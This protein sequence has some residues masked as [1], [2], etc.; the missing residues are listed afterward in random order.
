MAN[1]YISCDRST[2]FLLPPSLTDWL[3]EDHLAWFMIDAVGR[4]DTSA[5]HAVHPS[6]GPGRAAYDPDMMLTLLLYAYCTGT[7]SSRQIERACGE[8][9]AYRVITANE[10]PDHGTI[11][12]FR[13]GCE[14]HIEALFIKVLAM[15]AEAGMARLGIVALDGTKIAA[16]ASMK[17][18]RSQ[19]QIQKEVDALRAR[20]E[21]EVAAM[22]A[23]AAD[24]DAAQ[25]RLFGVDRGD[26][27]PKHLANPRSRLAH[28]EAALRRLEQR[29]DD[30]RAREREALADKTAKQVKA[31]RRAKHLNPRRPRSNPSVA[32][33]EAHLE[34]AQAQAEAAKAARAEL[35][36]AAQAEGRRLTGA[37]PDLDRGIAQAEAELAGAR[38]AE[39]AAAARDRINTTD[40]DSEIMKTRKGFLQGYNPQTVVSEDQIILAAEATTCAADVGQYVPMV[41]AALTN[42]AAAGIVEPIGYVL[43]DAGYV[44]DDN[45]GAPGPPRLIATSKVWKLRRQVGEE[46]FHTG[47]PPID[48]TLLESMTHRLLTEEGVATYAKRQYT[49]EPVFGQIKENRGYRRFMRRGRSA[50]NA[51]W[52]LLALTHNLLKLFAMQKEKASR[53]RSSILSGRS[54]VPRRA[55]PRPW[56]RISW[57]AASPAAA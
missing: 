6:S 3:P 20:I 40:C 1:N 30:A 33:A 14:D 5:L 38:F 42:I 37:T 54:G 43:A 55:V 8:D 12:R 25:D 52:K 18:T 45:L 36:A 2:P 16:S 50:V 19:A 47:P 34:V 26:E 29:R 56:I 51:E 21:K 11:A 57:S 32:Q 15:C 23:R 46:G 24:E 17:A 48:V 9:I 44:S 27:L 41:D 4:M 31:A 53:E 35:E 49:V 22:L 7:W 10:A 13:A 28:L 39:Q